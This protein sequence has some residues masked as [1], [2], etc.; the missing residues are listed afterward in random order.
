MSK[1]I[2]YSSTRARQVRA[3]RNG[4]HYAARGAKPLMPEFAVGDL[5]RITKTG[6]EATV[7][8]KESWGDYRLQGMDGFYSPSNLEL[9]KKGSLP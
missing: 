7:A 9:I 2:R 4:P 1:G 3:A 8:G 6:Q 5:V